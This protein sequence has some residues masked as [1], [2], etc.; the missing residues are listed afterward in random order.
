MIPDWFM[1]AVAARAARRAQKS[2]PPHSAK[3]LPAGFS[4][5]HHRVDLLRHPNTA[6]S[7]Q[8]MSCR[9]PRLKKK[10]QV[11][12]LSPRRAIIFLQCRR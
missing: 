9:T 12:P 7:Y 3:L 10:Q 4:R 1:G 8:Q 2:T 6:T 11:P 5:H